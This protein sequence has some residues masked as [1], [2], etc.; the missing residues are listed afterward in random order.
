MRRFS[1]LLFATILLTTVGL[2]AHAARPD[3]AERARN[4]IPAGAGLVLN[5]ILADTGAGDANGDGDTSSTSEDEFIEIVNDTGADLNVSGWKISDSISDRHIFPSG[6]I[7]RNGCAALIFGGGE[8]TG[9]FGGSLVQTASSNSLSLN[10]DGDTV[11]LK[12]AANIPQASYTYGTEANTDQ[13][14]T[15]SPDIS[16]PEPLIKHTLAPGAGGRV[17]SPGTRIDGT[18]LSANCLAADLAL[19]KVGPATASP[20]DTIQY[21]LHVV[22]QGDISADGIVITDTLPAGLSYINDTSGLPLSMPQPGILVWSAGSLG[23]GLSITFDISVNIAPGISGNLV[24]QSSTATDTPESNLNNNSGSATTFVAGIVIN[25]IL[26]DGNAGDA[27]HDGIVNDTNDELVEI[28]NNT[29]A[30]LSIS[31]WQLKDASSTR[32]TFPTGTTLGQ[33]CAIIVFGSGAPTGDFGGSL[34]QTASSGGLGLNNTGDGVTLLDGGGLPVGNVTYGAE[35]GNDQSLTRDPDILSATFVLHTTATGAGGAIYSPGTRVTGAPFQSGCVR[36]DLTISK[37]GPATAGANVDIV[38]TL[39]AGNVGGVSAQGVVI[40]DTLP[41]GLTYVNDSSG[42]PLTQ[43]TPG[44]LVWQ[45]GALAGGASLNFTLRVHVGPNVSGNVVNTV[46]IGGDPLEIAIGNNSASHTTLVGQSVLINAVLAD[47]Q[48]NNDIDEAVQLFNAGAIAI[49]LSGWKLNDGGSS[50]AIIPNGVSLAP[51]AS[52]WLTQSSAA[53]QEQF[54]FAAD[55]DMSQLAGSWPGYSNTGDEVILLDPNDMS[56]D[57]L[58]Y[59]TGNTGTVGWSGPALNSYGGTSKGAEGQIFYRMLNETTALPVPD[60]DQVGDWAQ[61]TQNVIDGRKVRYP[62]WDLE[63]FFFNEVLH[64]SAELKIAIAPDNAYE[65]IVAE[66]NAAQTSIQMESL[67]FTNVAL[68]QALVNA[69]NRGVQVT[70]L[71]EGAPAG[72]LSDQERYLCRELFEA[73]GASNCWFM[74]GDSAQNISPRYAFLHAKFILIDGQRAIISTENMSANSLAYDN[75]SDGTWGRRGVVVITDAPGVF[76]HLQ[77]IFNVDFD[78]VNHHDIVPWGSP[79][80]SQPP[81]GFIPDDSSGGI[82]YTV[83]YPTASTFTGTF[84]FEL[85]QSPENSLRDHGSLLG[86][87]GQVN[88]GDTLYVMQLDERPYWGDDPVTDPNPRME[89]YLAAAR[90]GAEVWILLDSYNNDQ[91]EIDPLDPANNLSTCAYAMSVANTEGLRVHCALGNPAGLGIHAKLVLAQIDGH[92]YVHIGSLNGT[93]NASKANREVAIQVQSDQAYALLAD[94]FIRDWPHR[95]YLPIGTNHAPARSNHLLIS[96][97]FYNP[98]GL[99]DDAEYIEIVNPTPFAVNIGG[100]TIGDTD[101][102]ADFEDVRIFPNGAVINSLDA[103]IVARRSSAFFATFGFKP[104]YEILNTDASVPDLLDDPRWDPNQFLQ[105]GNT[106][107]EVIF[108]NAAGQ[109]VDVVT[110][111]DGSYPGVIPAPLVTGTNSLERIPYFLDT[112]DGSRDF[113][114]RA[115]SPGVVHSN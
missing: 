78:P 45:A 20:G 112:N 94:M 110:Y 22:N 19:S 52:I 32:H 64:E 28:V 66:L 41:S 60:T 16:G 15:R 51:G 107:D 11:T 73:P 62:G 57:V 26:A 80:I 101:N 14:V 2:T 54:G 113:V 106:G 83:R 115:P 82:T 49:N 4:A 10:N 1:W 97:I 103:I 105:L 102:P 48:A 23:A 79:L 47:G 72:G 53:F 58:V 89:A 46:T 33:G 24:N 8:P 37:T 31:G 98:S 69:V 13:S 85:V 68:M 44:T 18:P 36:P 81:I 84:D 88:A 29:G 61:S 5:E 38:Y 34:V 75:K 35:G 71:L 99:E 30:D 111:G 50:K 109:I 43:P 42:L 40:T 77:A 17:F 86:L 70:V 7:I 74:L 12:D 63:Q 25:E 65:A 91:Y 6:S 55:Y 90:R 3:S 67:T 104:D 114:Q 27:N 39:T 100:Y 93:E 96:E 76:N 92:G 87:V 108:K 95:A 56:V 9:N 21:T 59:G